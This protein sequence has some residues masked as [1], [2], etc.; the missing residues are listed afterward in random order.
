MYNCNQKSS[1]ILGIIP[2]PFDIFLTEENEMNEEF[3]SGIFLGM[4][5]LSIILTPF[6][7]L[8]FIWTLA[9]LDMFWTLRTEGTCKAIMVNGV[10]K[11]FI[12]AYEYRR[13][14]SDTD[15]VDRWNVIDVNTQTQ[16]TQTKIPLIGGLSWVGIWP[17][18]QVYK[19][20][21][22]WT[23]LEQQQVE[24]SND[25]ALVAHTE[26]KEISYMI[27]QH[28]VYAVLITNVDT[29]EM[30]P[31]NVLLQ[32]SGRITNPY[33]ATFE[34]QH[35]LEQ[36]ENWI[37]DKTRALLGSLTYS[38]IVQYAKPDSEGEVKHIGDKLDDVLE[39]IKNVLGF[40]IDKVGIRRIDPA[41][42]E[43]LD[44]IKASGFVYI[45]DQRAK[46]DVIEGKGKKSR[47][48]DY[49]D[50]VANI[51]GGQGASMMWAENI[52]DSNI[53]VIGSGV[54]PTVIAEDASKDS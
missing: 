18:E 8:L 40:D 10:F 1:G 15:T 46:A 51:K 4:M 2:F 19:S 25:A 49:Y 26:N 31:V 11:K 54:I 42:K 45:A 52:R 14:Q 37:A 38:E 3:L 43:T 47:V 21:H 28:D 30:L 5:A 33:K 20:R 12:M 17:F 48:L 39:K 34:V 22:T 44:F 29:S 35:W 6:A 13:F 41:S 7:C 24:G 32:I 50:A 36:S 23:S 53:R 16:S 27:L 9:K